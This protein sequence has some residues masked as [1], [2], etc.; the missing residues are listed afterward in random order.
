MFMCEL[1]I[2]N[3]CDLIGRRQKP[4]GAPLAEWIIKESFLCVAFI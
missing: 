2:K 4:S 1:I 3:R